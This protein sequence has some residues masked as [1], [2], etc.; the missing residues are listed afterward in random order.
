LIKLSVDWNKALNLDL[1]LKNLRQDFIGDWYRDPWGWPE[2]NYVEA[3]ATDLVGLRAEALGVRRVANIDVP[4]ENFGMR[5]A[6]VMEPLDRLLYQ[7]L[8]DRLSKRLIGDLPNWVFGWRLRR[9]DPSAGVMARNDFEWA[10]QSSR[11]SLYVQVF[12]YGFKTDIVSCFASMPVELV[13]EEIERRAGHSPTAVRLTDMLRGW[14]AAPG[15]RGLP[16]RSA[17]SAVLGNM[18]LS[19]VDEVIDEYNASMLSKKKFAGLKSASTRWMDDI[20][21][22][23][24]DE[25]RLRRLQVDLQHAA[26]DANLELNSAKTALLEGP[27]LAE[28]ALRVNQSSIEDALIGDK[29]DLEPLEA[30]ID[31]II[32]FPESTDR[33]LIHFAMVRMRS[34]KAAGR[35]ADLVD[36]AP[37]M[38]HGSDHLARAFRAFGLWKDLDDWYVEHLNSDWGSFDWSSAQLCTM[39]P[40]S[41]SQS[42]KVVDALMAVL[43]RRPQLPMQAV[44]LQRLIKW[45]PES[46]RDFIRSRADQWDHP[47]ERRLLGLTSAALREPRR[48]TRALLGAYEEN[49]LTLKAVADRDFKPLP[50]VSDFG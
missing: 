49:G 33:T 12:D 31:Q 21:V 2:I 17:A 34:F 44:A 41:S 1:A 4:K 22:F 19:V 30:L 8:T 45:A 20:W 3:R 43:D 29:P 42:Q 13:S 37:R 39:F 23:G 11:L 15:R 32:E 35:L 25:G 24:K 9:K 38:P 5:P 18:Y 16:Q 28:E 14:E 47:L 40:S 46:L 7:A 26:R 6:I 50:V 10:V 36:V 48:R 27:D